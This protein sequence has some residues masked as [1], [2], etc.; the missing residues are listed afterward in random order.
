MKLL[1][2]LKHYDDAG[3]VKPPLGAYLCGLFLCRSIIVLV[4]ALSSSQYSNE[5]LNVVYPQKILLYANI[6]LALPVLAS[7]G[8]IGFREKIWA[9]GACWLFL[10]IKP[11]LL[12]TALGELLFY[13]SLANY[14]HWEFSWIIALTILLSILCLYYLIKDKHLI[15]MLKDWGKS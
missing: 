4:A 14:H 5:L 10:L 12:V 3:R 11:C 1:L 15:Y 2:P 6:V 9:K 7:L 8:I 13:L